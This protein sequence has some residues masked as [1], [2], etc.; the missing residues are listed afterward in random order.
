MVEYYPGMSSIQKNKKYFLKIIFNLS[1]LLCS[2]G[3]RKN[4]WWHNPR[5]E[6]DGTAQGN[7]DI[8]VSA[9]LFKLSASEK[10]AQTIS[11]EL[12]IVG[13][14]RVPSVKSDN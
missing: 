12:F 5:S 8:Q 13:N 14:Q 2:G 10:L 9:L 3:W 11:A 7:D 6:A 1:G 4:L